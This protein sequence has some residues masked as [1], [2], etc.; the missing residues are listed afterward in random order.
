MNVYTHALLCP[1]TG[2]SNWKTIQTQYIDA[3][4]IDKY[5]A[6]S[7]VKMSKLNYKQTM[8]TNQDAL[9]EVEYQGCRVKSL[10]S[11]MIIMLEPSFKMNTSARFTLFCFIAVNILYYCPRP[12]KK[13]IKLLKRM[14]RI[15]IY[16]III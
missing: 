7:T 13:T 4:S 16:I 15:Y 3:N 9:C 12:I 14:H 2:I 5:W 6:R 10:L 1:V 11:I 8:Y